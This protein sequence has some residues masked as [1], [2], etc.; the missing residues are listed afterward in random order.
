MVARLEAVLRRG[1]WSIRRG[2]SYLLEGWSSSC[3]VLRRGVWS[4]KDGV[5]ATCRHRVTVQGRNCVSLICCGRRPFI[6]SSHLLIMG[7]PSKFVD[8][9]QWWGDGLGAFLVIN[10][11]NWQSADGSRGCACGR[12]KNHYF[13]HLPMLGLLT[14]RVIL[15]VIFVLIFCV[16]F[17][18]LNKNWLK[19]VKKNL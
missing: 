4:I 19:N 7:G 3:A 2:I 15:E 17:V 11:Q 8:S 12:E 6:S 5:S 16:C 10:S 18:C 13:R 1:V 9:W 14:M